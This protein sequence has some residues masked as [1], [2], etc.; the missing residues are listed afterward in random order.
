MSKSP[1][2]CGVTHLRAGAIISVG[3]DPSRI[4]TEYASWTRR[5]DGPQVLEPTSTR[6]ISWRV[7]CPK[8]TVRHF[9]VLETLAPFS[10]TVAPDLA[11]RRRSSSPHVWITAEVLYVQ[12]FDDRGIGSPGSDRGTALHHDA[13]SIIRNRASS[14]NPR[15]LLPRLDLGSSRRKSFYLYPRAPT[16]KESKCIYDIKFPYAY[17]KNL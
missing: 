5:V 4:W 9:H 6:Y 7:G 14:G 8:G 1:W 13:A 10:P 17:K 12:H 11:V 16:I 3:L 15:G 2:A